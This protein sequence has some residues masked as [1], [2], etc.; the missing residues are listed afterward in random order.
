MK[1]RKR[2]LV[3]ALMLVA[4]ASAS[5]DVIFDN[6]WG[7]AP[8]SGSFANRDIIGNT[9]QFDTTHVV[10]NRTG[11]V[12]TF[13]IY[14]SFA[15]RSGELF[16][17]YTRD[18]D[19][20]NR[21]GIGYGDLFLASSWTPFGSGNHA[22]DNATNG[23]LWSYGLVLSNRFDNSGGDL[24]LYELNGS[25]NDQ[26]ALLSD[27]FMTGN[28]IWRSPQEVAVDTASET[29]SGGVNVGSWSVQNGYLSLTANLGITSLLSGGELA[30]HW[31]MTCANDV[32]EG[33][34]S[35]P[36]PNS[37]ALLGAGLIAVA[38]VKRRRRTRKSS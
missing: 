3:S 35:V 16:S 20:G 12:V 4:S 23:T 6:Y 38:A 31:T 10:T 30:F 5:A 25:S 9:G 28:A 34:A 32:I 17:S 26:N 7:A 14:T 13:D 11:D 8:T 2:F 24:T 22:A 15:G 1:L 19:S 33:S 37:L 29:V 21:T 36:E 18:P 27:D